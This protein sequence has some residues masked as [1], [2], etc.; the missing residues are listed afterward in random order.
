MSEVASPCTKVCRLD[1]THGW[2]VG[3]HR[4]G[5]EIA[6][7]TRLDDAGKREV[8]ERCEPRKGPAGDGRGL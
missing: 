5:S 8:L 1:P 3:C 7:W 2:C 6:A 4:T